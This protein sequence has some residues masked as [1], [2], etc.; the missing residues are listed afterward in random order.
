MHVIQVI[1]A[2]HDRLLL[3]TKDNAKRSLT[4]AYHWSRGAAL[5]NKKL[6][7]PIL[8]QD[9]DALWASAAM[10]GIANVTSLEA[11]TPTEAWPLKSTESSDLTWL[12]LTRG[13]MAL[14]DAT[15]PLRPD[16]IFHSMTDE[17][18]IISTEPSLLAPENMLPEFVE[19]CRL[20]EPL[21]CEHNPYYAPV[22][23][24]SRLLPIKC[25]QATMKEYLLFLNFMKSPFRN[26]LHKKDSRALLI[27]AYWYGAM[28]D[29]LWWVERRARLEC[30]AIC[31]Y[32]ENRHGDEEDVQKMLLV[33]RMQC[34][35]A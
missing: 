17:Y 13:K 32:L 21:A 3:N 28:W 5:L 14:W 12:Y 11:F 6:S 26:L 10:L 15:D 19:L 33:P 29:S 35:L 2:T 27:M 16:S 1:T 23:I 30:Q 34:G 8:P 31:L 4:E 7:F 18:A 25:E 20:N 22:S 24:L 9:R